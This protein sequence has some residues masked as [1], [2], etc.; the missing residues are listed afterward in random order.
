MYACIS[1][2][3]NYGVDAEEVELTEVN[4]VCLPEIPVIPDQFATSLQ[5]ILGRDSTCF[6]MDIFEDCLKYVQ[7]S[8]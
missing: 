6:K 5:H 3:N 2:V 8:M 7:D 1:Q 4:S